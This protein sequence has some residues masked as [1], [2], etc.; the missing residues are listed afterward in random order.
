MKVGVVGAGLYGCVTAVELA[1][2]GVEVELIER[3]SEI[4]KGASR[5]NQG[6]VHQG[7]HYP[8]S[9]ETAIEA[10][11]QAPRFEARFGAAIP[12]V[13]V[14]HYYALAPESRTTP[15]EYGVFL[16]GLGGG[17]RWFT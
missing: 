5:A 13:E 16:A 2:A 7:F 11:A 15:H 4:M 12:Q 3:R 10:Q 17:S 1:R 9:M 6:R 14:D 8:R